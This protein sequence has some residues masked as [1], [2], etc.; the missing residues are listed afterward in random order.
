MDAD[1]VDIHDYAECRRIMLGA[2][3]NYSAASQFLPPDRRHYVEALYALLRV[4][5]DRVD[6][7]HDGFRTPLEAIDDWERL[8]WDAFETGTSPHPVM[9]AYLDT[10]ITCGI[11]AELM[12]PYF[13][14]MRDDLTVTRFPDFAALRYYMEGSAI[15]VGRAMVYILGTRTPYTVVDALPG[16]DDLAIAMQL[17]NFWR[18]IWQDWVRGGRIYI[19]QEDLDRF[20][21]SEAD[22]AARRI[23][24]NLSDLM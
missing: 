23:N 10:A 1:I 21:Y 9:R 22:L 3:R 11:P 18:D 14:A 7:S 4:G 8:Y 17:S 6:V 12:R 20:G 5:D 15:P 19:P 2:S 16:A 24:Q 13:R